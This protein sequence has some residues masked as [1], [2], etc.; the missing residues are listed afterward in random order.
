MEGWRRKHPR[1]RFVPFVFALAVSAPLFY[2]SFF[3]SPILVPSVTAK[4]ISQNSIRTLDVYAMGR[5][6]QGLI[7]VSISGSISDPSASR[8]RLTTAPPGSADLSQDQPNCCTI[9]DGIFVGT[10][11]LGTAESPVTGTS[12][13]PFRFESGDGFLE[14]A[15]NFAINVESLPGGNRWAFMVVS[16]LSILT[17]I[18]AFLQAWHPAAEREPPAKEQG[19]RTGKVE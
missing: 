6:N 8:L 14:A 16:F 18:M 19:K 12:A 3:A 4:Q 5:V 15:G 13:V 9:S 11:L 10:A 2:F 17:T 7:P 1:L